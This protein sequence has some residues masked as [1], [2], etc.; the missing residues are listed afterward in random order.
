MLA[1]WTSC[2]NFVSYLKIPWEDYIRLAKTDTQVDNEIREYTLSH[3]T[4]IWT[5]QHCLKSY[6]FHWFSVATRGK[7]SG[8]GMLPSPALDKVILGRG[9]LAT[10]GGRKSMSSSSSHRDIKKQK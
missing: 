5:W 9:Y 6:Y 10:G 3:G 7:W 2:K 1:D 8:R 4:N